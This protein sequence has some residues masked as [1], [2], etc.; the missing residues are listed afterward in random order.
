[1]IVADACAKQPVANLWIEFA[2]RRVYSMATNGTGCCR[3]YG[4]GPRGRRFES[5]RPDHK[6]QTLTAANTGGRISF[7]PICG[8]PEGVVTSQAMQNVACTSC[9]SRGRSGGLGKV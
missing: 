9:H 6:H 1:M 7:V 4:S 5:S 3:A 2:A 8:H